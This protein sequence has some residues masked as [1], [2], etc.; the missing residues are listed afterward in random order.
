MNSLKVTGNN[1][2]NIGDNIN[3]SGVISGDGNRVVIDRAGV[4][5]SIRINING[6]NNNI[7]ICRP[8][9]INSLSIFC[10]NSVK[11]NGTNLIIGRNISMEDNARIFLYNSENKC[12][13][14]D[15]CLISNNLTIRCGEAP[16]LIFDKLSGDFLDYS[17]GVFIG[18]HVWI[19]EQ[20]YITKKVT[21]PDESIVAACSVVTKRFELSNCVLA[22]NPAA[23]VKKNIQWVRNSQF[24]E[25]DSIYTKK[26]EEWMEKLNIR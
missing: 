9:R 25:K 22:G 3:V 6:D 13:I 1:N 19:G 10:G 7:E 16:H 11:A 5:S 23:I 14:G 24:L 20:V 12:V 2:V 18:D 8:G 21:I 17:D 26:Y 4:E 15:Q